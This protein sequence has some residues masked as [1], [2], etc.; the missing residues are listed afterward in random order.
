M[1]P[2]LS[3]KSQVRE[4]VSRLRREGKTVGFVPTMGALHEGHLSL[5]RVAAERCDAV[6]VSVFVNPTQFGPNE[7]F[8]RYPRTLDADVTLLA[9]D[10]AGAKVAAVF[11]PSVEEMYGPALEA[12][13]GV[14]PVRTSVTPG[15][16]S[17][18]WEGALRPGHFA[19]V[20]LVVTK[21]LSTVRPDYAF[22]G[23]KDYQQLAVLRQLNEDL[24]LGVQLVGCPI[25]REPDGLALSSRNRYLA[26]AHRAL[27]TEIYRS[28]QLARS[29]FAEGERS[30]GTIAGAVE[31]H[32]L[33]VGADGD[34][35]FVIGYVAVVDG[36]TLE[37][38]GEVDPNAR[39]LISVELGGTHLIDNASL[40]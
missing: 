10:P 24:D 3:E 34:G 11:A 30:A 7:D 13:G 23:E 20:A 26:P 6:I 21:L 28:I 35:G 2:I 31:R 25:L 4:L 15:A 14:N 16:V 5:V 17:H 18:L 32:L 36:R 33:G 12:N 39:L 8:D 29:L 40:T 9:G 22:F 1:L 38:L 19:G 37:P 27:A